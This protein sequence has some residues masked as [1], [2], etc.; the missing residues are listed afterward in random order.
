M[1][2]R[3]SRWAAALAAVLLLAGA[4]GGA[5][6]DGGIAQYGDAGGDGSRSTTTAAVDDGDDGAPATTRGSGSGGGG[7]GGGAATPTTAGRSGGGGSGGRTSRPVTVSGP[8]GSYA[9]PLLRASE[10]GTIVLDVLQQAGAELREAT[11]DHV[12]RVLERESAKPVSVAITEIP[13]A[14]AEWTADE[15]TSTADDRATTKATSDRHVVHLLAV[16]GR[17]EEPGTLGV[18]VRG[19][20]AAIFTDEVDRAAT[21][22]VRAATIEDAVTIHELGHLLGLVDLALD[23]NRDDPDHPGHSKNRESVMYWAIESNLVAQVLGGPPSTEFDD[24]DRADLARLRGG[25]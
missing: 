5:D 1:M 13:G 8:P 3:R 16:H 23:T 7:G 22:L 19:N 10:G 20:V 18:A 12:V 15:I 2:P 9:R 17:Y 11:L 24:D 4:C 14:Q 25:A 21:P 6:E